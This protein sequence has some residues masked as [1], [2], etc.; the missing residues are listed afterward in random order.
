MPYCESLKDR[1]RFGAKVVALDQD[2]VLSLCTTLCW[3]GASRAETT[4]GHYSVC[5]PALCGSSA[6]VLPRQR[7]RSHAGTPL[8][9]LHQITCAVPATI[10]GKRTRHLWRQDDDLPIRTIYYRSTA[11]RPVEGVLLCQLYLGR[12]RAAMGLLPGCSDRL[13][14]CRAR[15]GS[16]TPEYGRSSKLVPRKRGRTIPMLAVPLLPY[17]SGQQSLLYEHYRQT[18]SISR[19]STRRQTMLDSGGYPLRM[20]TATRRARKRL[21][22]KV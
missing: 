3:A 15:C 1:I 20:G 13:V 12:R 17:T 14:P 10:L 16:F 8:R 18:A 21:D 7:S 11:E 6:A 22:I 2:S 5:G 9:C 19:E 4:P